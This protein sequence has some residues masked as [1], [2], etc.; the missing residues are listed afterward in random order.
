MRTSSLCRMPTHASPHGARTTK[1]SMPVGR[2]V[3]ICTDTPPTYQRVTGTAGGSPTVPGSPIHRLHVL[4]A[5]TMCR[6]SSPVRALPSVWWACS[7][8]PSHAWGPGLFLSHHPSSCALQR[9]RWPVL[10]SFVEWSRPSTS[11]RI[12]RHDRL[13]PPAH[14]LLI[15]PVSALQR[16][17]HVI[18]VV[19][20]IDVAPRAVVL[21]GAVR[22]PVDRARARLTEPLGAAIVD[23]LASALRGHGPAVRG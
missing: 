14:V 13:D 16:H 8:I 3:I 21:V 12:R 4:H 15:W 19:R 9:H 7:M 5:P 11:S 23:H 2:T 18:A 10:G 22:L 17:G 20:R 1:S 6:G